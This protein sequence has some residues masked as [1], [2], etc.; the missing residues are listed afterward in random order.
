MTDYDRTGTVSLWPA[1][2]DNPK[3]PKFKG[4]LYAHRDYRAGEEIE[5]SLWNGNKANPHAP[6]Y[7]PKAPR[8]TGKL[9]DKFVP[10]Q[11][12]TMRSAAPNPDDFDDSI[13]F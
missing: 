1:E 4:K 2:S 8:F 6:D 10:Q 11:G 7:N 3:A 5:I 13:P 12:T 9:Q